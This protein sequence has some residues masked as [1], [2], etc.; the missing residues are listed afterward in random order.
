MVNIFTCHLILTWL[1]L[2]FML[3]DSQSGLNGE[4]TPVQQVQATL[5]CERRNFPHKLY[6]AIETFVR[7]Y[8]T[9][10]GDWLF[11]DSLWSNLLCEFNVSILSK[12]LPHISQRCCLGLLPDPVD[13][14]GALA[15]VY[16]YSVLL[17]LFF[18]RCVSNSYLFLAAL[19]GRYTET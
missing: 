2:S 15:I 18:D 5:K 19:T 16:K 11:P 6:F 12:L 4:R 17:K 13:D 14:E 3:W 1:R 8:P 9:P 7:S 10:A